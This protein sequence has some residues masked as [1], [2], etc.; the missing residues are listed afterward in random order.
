MGSDAI[1]S[2]IEQLDDTLAHSSA[3]VQKDVLELLGLLSFPVTRGPLT[4]IWG[5]WD[6][7]SAEQLNSFVQ[8]W[9]DSRLTMLR[10]GH[11]ALSQL[12]L[13]SWYAQPLAW[14]AAGYPGPPVI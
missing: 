10:L 14:E 9:R 5:S 6:E 1:A 2:A 3:A 11:Q 13:M 8:R 4:R 7:A 12:L